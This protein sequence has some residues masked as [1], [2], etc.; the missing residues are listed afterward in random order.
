MEAPA[1]RT[2]EGSCPP[3]HPVGSRAVPHA[4]GQR[5]P[6][7]QLSPQGKRILSAGFIRNLELPGEKKPAHQQCFIIAGLHFISFLKLRHSGLKVVC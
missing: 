5:Q 3:P 1:V 4:S 6:S 2:S 7:Q